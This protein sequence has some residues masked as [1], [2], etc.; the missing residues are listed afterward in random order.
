MTSSGAL[1]SLNTDSEDFVDVDAEVAAL[2]RSDAPG[3]RAARQWV[4]RHL[5]GDTTS[6]LRAL[7]LSKGFSQ[8]ALA[9]AMGVNQGQMSRWENGKADMRVSTLRRL[10]VVLG[11]TQ[12]DVF[13][14]VCGGCPDEDCGNV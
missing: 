5:Y 9:A 11:V 2:E 10:A 6:T 7:R 1:P 8:G 4:G 3:V 12:I 14:A 13:S